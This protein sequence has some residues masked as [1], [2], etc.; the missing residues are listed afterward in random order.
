MKHRV[1]SLYRQARSSC[2]RV[3]LEFLEFC[4]V[5]LR[6]DIC[7]TIGTPRGHKD[8]P[9]STPWVDCWAMASLPKS[10]RLRRTP[11]MWIN[12]DQ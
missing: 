9:R 10:L 1:L 8:G 3:F 6:A 7:E 5:I 12:V 4:D 2:V 11:D